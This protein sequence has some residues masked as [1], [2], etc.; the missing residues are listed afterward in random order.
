LRAVTTF[1]Y[2]KPSCAF[3]SQVWL[4][5]PRDVG[6][7]LVHTGIR[8][9]LDGWGVRL[10]RLPYRWKKTDPR[11]IHV[12]RKYLYLLDVVLFVTKRAETWFVA[13]NERRGL[14]IPASE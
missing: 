6:L 10:V 1:P 14:Q 2:Q 5:A 13:F 11:F 12:F 8:P 4:N 7:R 3:S 9:E